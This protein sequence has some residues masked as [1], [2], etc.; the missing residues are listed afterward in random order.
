MSGNF[1]DN[2]LKKLDPRRP[3]DDAPV[4]SRLQKFLSKSSNK[5]PNPKFSQSVSYTQPSKSS[6][7]M[8]KP[9]FPEK[10]Q[11]SYSNSHKTS[12]SLYQKQ[13]EY[14]RNYTKYIDDLE[15]NIPRDDLFPENI[16]KKITSLPDFKIPMKP[17][18][19]PEDGRAIF[20]YLTKPKSVPEEKKSKLKGKGLLQK[21][22]VWCARCSK[23][24]DPDFHFQAK[25]SASK[26]KPINLPVK[27]IYREQEEY[28][29]EEEE[30]E[31]EDEE[32]DDGF[33]VKDEN[34]EVTKK[35][36]RGITGFDPSRYRD[37]DRLPT[38]GMESSADRVLQEDRYTS[39]IARI[40]DQRE[41]ERLKRHR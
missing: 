2:G 30:E 17:D 15:S 23:K 14:S 26:N 6:N 19:D 20:N 7:F 35:M 24:H 32:E 22:E 4:P 21:Q 39:K 36:V 11:E 29:D 28:Y 27:R 34:E 8:P 25:P 38:Y 1:Q 5:P 13:L 33:I 37:I 10:R 40:E 18:K 31:D 12:L 16:P 41:L 3:P 9:N